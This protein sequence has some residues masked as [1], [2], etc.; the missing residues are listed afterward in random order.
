M[1]TYKVHRELCEMNTPVWFVQI[2]SN[3][4][5]VATYGFESFAK[6]LQW[7]VNDK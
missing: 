3:Y 2:L 7:I 6:A 4:T 5:Y 1:K